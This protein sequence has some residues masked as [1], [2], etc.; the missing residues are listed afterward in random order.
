MPVHL[1]SFVFRSRPSYTPS[2]PADGCHCV[3]MSR[4][5]T[6]KSFVSVSGRLVKTPC[7]DGA[8]ICAQ[9]TQAADENR[10]LRRRQ[11]Q[12]LRPIDHHGSSA[13]RRCLPRTIVAETVSDRLEHREGL[14]VRLVLPGVHSSGREG[15]LHLDAGVLRGLLD[16]RAAREHDQVGKGDFLPAGLRSVEPLP[17]LF[18]RRQHL[19]Q[20]GRLVDLPI[21]LRREAD[22][23]AVRA[24]ALVGAAEGR[25]RRPGGR[26]QLRHRQPRSQHLALER[27]DVLL[28][29]QLLVDG[30]DGVLPDEFF[31]QAPPVPGS[32]R[33]G[34]Y[35]GASA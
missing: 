22:A 26:D 19:R 1:T 29:D 23:R 8:G 4:R 14:D 15:N 20:L 13:D 11:R 24:T 18:E 5:L 34:P 21:L 33:A 10:H 16:T 32:G 9:D 28:I 12:Q 30:R 31:R 2:A 17:D 27:G 3:R 25:R 35:R 7:L 6:K